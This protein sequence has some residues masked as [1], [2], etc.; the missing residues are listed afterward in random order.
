MPALWEQPL[1]VT[2]IG[3]SQ[4]TIAALEKSGGLL[5]PYFANRVSEISSNLIEV[6]KITQVSP[7]YHV[8]G[9]MN[10]A[11]I[12]TRKSSTSADLQSSSIWMSGPSFLYD[13]RD[14]MP[15]TLSLIHI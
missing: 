4:C 14:C 8:A 5:A 1:S 12:P 7:V 13:D 15:L 2:I 11:D 9:P 6:S 10:P 3:D